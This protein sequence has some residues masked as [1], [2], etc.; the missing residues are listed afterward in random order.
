MPLHADRE[1]GALDRLDRAVGGAGG[2]P[3]PAAEAVDRLVVEG[4]DLD[5]A[6][7]R[8]APARRVPAST[9]TS[10]ET[11]QPGSLWRWPGRCWCSVPPQATL[12]ACAPRQMPSSGIP[13]SSAARASASSKASSDGSVGP[14]SAW[15]SRRPVGLGIQVGAAGEADAVEPG[16]QRLEVRHARRQ[17]DRH[18]AGALDRAAGRSSR[19]PS[20]GG[21]ARPGGAASRARSGAA[22]RWS[23]RSAAACTPVIDQFA[24]FRHGRMAKSPAEVPAAGRIYPHRRCRANTS[25]PCTS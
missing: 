4:V 6:R 23:R 22:P 24:D 8:S 9:S 19:A 11:W 5:R 14:S 15:R 12:S 20:P 13:R 17:H 1:A 2:D 18:R 10:W 16:D 7:R 21:P 3:Q 25:S